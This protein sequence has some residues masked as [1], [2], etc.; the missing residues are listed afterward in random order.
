[1]TNTSHG[2]IHGRT[3]ELD[4]DLGI[5][6]GQEVEVTVKPAKSQRPWGEGINRSAGAAADEPEFD[7]VFEQIARVRNR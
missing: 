6:D 3:I 7:A 1:M 2:R 5:A 4:E